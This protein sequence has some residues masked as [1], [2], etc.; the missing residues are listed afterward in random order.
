MVNDLETTLSRP[1]H[2][3]QA[4]ST[5]IKGRPYKIQCDQYQSME[6]DYY[7]HL[8]SAT[9]SRASL[10]S[11]QLYDRWTVRHPGQP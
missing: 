4:I 7:S 6:Q 11:D 9:R 3:L 8:L 10:Q 5:V 1:P 2:E